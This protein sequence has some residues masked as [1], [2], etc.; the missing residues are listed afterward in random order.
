MKLE[1]AIYYM[2]GKGC[3]SARIFQ[4]NKTR[5]DIFLETINSEIKQTEMKSIL[6]DN[7]FVVA[8]QTV[9]FIQ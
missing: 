3:S 2:I 4:D 8:S 1:D 5:I 7:E 9:K 6:I